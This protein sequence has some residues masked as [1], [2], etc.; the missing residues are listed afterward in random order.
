MKTCKQCGK[1]LSFSEFYKNPAMKDG[2]WAKCK[3]CIREYGRTRVSYYRGYRKA[4]RAKVRANV[5]NYRRKNPSVMLE[6]VACYRSKNQEKIRAQNAINCQIRSG[7][8]KRLPCEKCGN[9]RSHA[10]HDDYNKPLE[11]R[12]LCAI[13]HKEQHAMKGAA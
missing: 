5:Y 13:H 12:W 10:H 9:P 3:S 2:Y 8:V 11:V 7:K 1:T 6:A 4:N